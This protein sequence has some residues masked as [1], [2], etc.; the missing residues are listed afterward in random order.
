MRISIGFEFQTNH[1]SVGLEALEQSID[2]IPKI[3]H[4]ET[5][6]LMELK[7][8]PQYVL[9]VYGDALSQKDDNEKA[10]NSLKYLNNRYK[11]IILNDSEKIHIGNDYRYLLNDA[12]FLV[13]Y[14]K[15]QTV[16]LNQLLSFMQL[17]TKQGIT[18]IH[19]FLK[20]K[21]SYVPIKSI[22]GLSKT[23]TRQRTET[24]FP[25][26]SF[27]RIPNKN[28]EKFDNQIN[29]TYNGIF[30]SPL[31]TKPK[32]ENFSYYIQVT[33]G[34]DLENVWG[35]MKLLADNVIETPKIIQSEK[36]KTKTLQKIED[37]LDSTF[38]ESRLH[39][40]PRALYLL[41]VYSFQNR[42]VDKKSEPFIIRHHF[43]EL[44]KLMNKSQ[45]SL[46]TSWLT[47]DA[48]QYL[49]FQLYRKP[50]MISIKRQQRTSQQADKYLEQK[51]YQGVN[52]VGTYPIKSDGLQTMILFEFRYWNAVLNNKI[53]KKKGTHEFI[54][55]HEL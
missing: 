43:V 17:K 8:T 38:P 9:S 21:S 3:F 30:L 16:P 2:P 44:L 37:E 14:P 39:K 53:S 22:K 45:M 52:Y 15:I 24:N 35:V 7:T 51:I 26:H 10:I 1:L 33:L 11:T 29:T 19:D 47:T 23:S 40:L 31:S 25:F 50:S 6:M 48:L 32:F 4:P 41:F 20:T 18:S 27:L 42:S 34:I 13:T 5:I 12:E 55:L 36:N 46:M 54:K 28:I 49:A